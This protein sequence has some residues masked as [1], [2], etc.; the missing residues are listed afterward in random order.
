MS[1]NPNTS[2]ETTTETANNSTSDSLEE[3]REPVRD[4]ASED[5]SLDT[6]S[7]MAS[8]F[9]ED[10]EDAPPKGEESSDGEEVTTEEVPTETKPEEGEKP[11]EEVPGEEET[12]EEETTKPAASDEEEST[13]ETASEKPKEGGEEEKPEPSEEV[14][15]D[16]Q[17][18]KLFELLNERRGEAVETL[19]KTHFALSDEQMQD[20]DENPREAI[21][22]LLASLYIDAVQGSVSTLVAQLPNIVQT[23]NTNTE[24]ARKAEEAF[25]EAFPLLGSKPEYRA[26]VAKVA[27]LHRKLNP[28]ASREEMIRD[29]GVQTSLAFKLPIPGAENVKGKETAEVKPFKSAGAEGQPTGKPVTKSQNQFEQLA[30]EMLEDDA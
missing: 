11:A 15:T 29:V 20:I 26:H 25:F 23:I 16:E 30:E 3:V 10:D 22:K 17:T 18:T 19:A 24:E 12:A 14:A 21:P 9:D 13:A 28:K 8:L 6:A 27:K 4:P 1:D 5:A 7:Q 2:Q